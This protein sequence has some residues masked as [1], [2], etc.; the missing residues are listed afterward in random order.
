[1]ANAQNDQNAVNGE[2]QS[3]QE[4]LEIGSKRPI[5][6]KGKGEETV[7]SLHLLN[8]I[9]DSLK[10]DFSNLQKEYSAL[11]KRND[12]YKQKLERADKVLSS[13]ASNFLY[14]PYEAYG[15]ENVAIR[16]FETIN[17][18]ALRRKHEIDYVL[19]KNY[20]SDIKGFLSYLRQAKKKLSNPFELKGDGAASLL[21]G[22]RQE[23]Y[24]V[25][26]HEYNDWSQTYIGKLI[27]RVENQ[28]KNNRANFDDIIKEL[29]EC[30]KTAA[31]L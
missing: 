18:E 3:E 16:A 24:Y 17:D 7:D 6:L 25:R 13:T 28:L 8:Q 19:L 14:I 15:V 5:A 21:Q 27:M 20:Q 23:V 11:Q 31:D 2:V 12:E 29:E 4:N 30:L 10:R 1:M 22:F 26:Y 9:C